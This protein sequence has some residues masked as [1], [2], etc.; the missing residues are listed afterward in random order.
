VQDRRFG[1][2]AEVDSRQATDKSRL[3]QRVDHAIR[4]P[5]EHRSVPVQSMDEVGIVRIDPLLQRQRCDVGAQCD[6]LS[7]RT[8]LISG[9]QNGEKL[10]F[11]RR[12]GVVVAVG[13][14]VSIAKSIEKAVGESIGETIGGAVKESADMG[15]GDGTNLYIFGTTQSR[16][17][18]SFV[19]AGQI[20]QPKV[21]VR[22]LENNM[23]VR[24]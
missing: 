18:L 6:R 17:W 10:A 13:E 9:R 7:P 16:H 14:R 20:S 11:G 12:H 19:D 3:F 4:P 21:V 15:I 23:C 24:T 1:G 5:A 22:I 2:Y 8:V